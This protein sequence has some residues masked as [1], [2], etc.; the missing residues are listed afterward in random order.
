VA[1]AKNPAV[2]GDDSFNLKR[3]LEAQDPVYERVLGELRSGRKATH[4]MWF[5]F[6]QIEGLGSSPMAQRYAISGR[7]EAAAY[8]AHPVLGARLRECTRAVNDLRGRSARDVFGSPDDLKFRS[9]MTLFS[10]CA[11]EPRPF[12]E[13]LDRYFDGLED[14]LTVRKLADE[15]PD[16]A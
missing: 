14:Q 15:A 7:E 9:C 11:E 13:A 1:S 5:V 4:W 10:R 16:K 3:F 8:A 2:Q 12:R 6:P